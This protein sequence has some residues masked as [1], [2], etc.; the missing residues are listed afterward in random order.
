M[1]RV[2]TTQ[3]VLLQHNCRSNRESAVCSVYSAAVLLLRRMLCL[4][5]ISG[6][7]LAGCVRAQTIHL[8]VEA[9]AQQVRREQ[10]YARMRA[11]CCALSLPV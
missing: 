9:G 5:D 1:L 7:A 8:Q 2:V 3:L 11:R 6:D 4:S 10:T